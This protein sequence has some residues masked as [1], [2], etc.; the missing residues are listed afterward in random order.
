LFNHCDSEDAD[1][2]RKFGCGSTN[3]IF[4]LIV[5]MFL[6]IPLL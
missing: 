4:D 6:R 5:D 3:D 2:S 1:S